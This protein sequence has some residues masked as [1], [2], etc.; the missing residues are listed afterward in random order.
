MTLLFVAT[1]LAFAISIDIY[2][3]IS[4]AIRSGNT[5]EVVKYFDANVDL[6]ILTQEDVYSKAQAELI[7]KD[8][9][10]KNTPKSFTLLHKGTSKEGAMYAIGNLV[11]TQGSTFRTYFFIKQNAGKYYIKELRFEKE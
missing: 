9:F 6:T 1:S 8:F 11:T 3:E 5:K 2:E 10:T 4:N 7:I